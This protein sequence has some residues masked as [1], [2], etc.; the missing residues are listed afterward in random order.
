MEA[1]KEQSW[2]CGFVLS[3][4]GQHWHHSSFYLIQG[5]VL[6]HFTTALCLIY[7]ATLFDLKSPLV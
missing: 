4:Q 2:P 7:K 1:L 3:A 5:F 6:N